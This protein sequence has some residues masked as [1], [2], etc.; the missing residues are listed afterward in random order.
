MKKQMHLYGIAWDRPRFLV[1]SNNGSKLH[2]VRE[3]Y[4]ILV[5]Y[6][7]IDLPASSSLYLQAMAGDKRWFCLAK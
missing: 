6:I 3:L 2:F 7:V 1:V 5:L 4:I